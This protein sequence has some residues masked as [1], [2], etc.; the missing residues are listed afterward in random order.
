MG[1]DLLGKCALITGASRGIGRA[2]ALAYAEAGA[3][4]AL[5][6]RSADR[7][8]GVAAL[9]RDLGRRP[10]ILPVDLTAPDAA[11]KAVAVAVHEFGRLDV[12]VN[13]AGGSSFMSPVATMRESGWR[14]TQAL[15]LD[16]TMRMSQA[17]A[18]ILLE[19][20]SGAVVN[21][22]SVSG[23]K[24]MPGMAHY[25]AAK[26]AVLSLTRTMAVE[27][28]SAGVRVNALAPGW[29]ATDLTEFARTDDSI[30]QSLISRVPMGR[31]ATPEEVAWPA[32][33][34]GSDAASFVTGQTLVVDGGLTVA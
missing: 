16:A 27:W 1:I 19:Q 26:A 13:N 31:W 9:V 17:V 15:N 10:I 8:E 34:L 32:V 7:L 28:A 25:G 3:D 5:L 18:Q 11:Q 14:S 2:I 33:F 21:V 29:V 4:V 22:S 24:A 20:R 12:V 30:G 23:L 6:A